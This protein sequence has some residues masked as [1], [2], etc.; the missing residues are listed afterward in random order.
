VE[1]LARGI[2]GLMT[3]CSL[4]CGCHCVQ[5]LPEPDG[6]TADRPATVAALLSMTHQP[7]PHGL[8]LPVRRYSGFAVLI[9]AVL[10]SL[11]MLL[12]LPSAVG[13]SALLGAADGDSTDSVV[14]VDGVP[15]DGVPAN[16][17]PADFDGQPQMVAVA[18]LRFG[19]PP[20]EC[21][22]EPEPDDEDESVGRIVFGAGAVW[23]ASPPRG[24]PAPVEFGSL[25]RLW[26]AGLA[27]RAPPV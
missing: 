1:C 4:D 10:M 22:S 19:C 8:D 26:L 2:C 13:M 15:A 11:V 21:E 25:R 5:I 23:F 27:A 18:T 14:L 24:G 20:C 7:Q 16:G 17:V 6:W 12:L 3:F 9:P